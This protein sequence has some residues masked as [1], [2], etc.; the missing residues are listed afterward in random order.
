MF[1]KSTDILNNPFYTI[2]L[3]SILTYGF[4]RQITDYE[5]LIKNFRFFSVVVIVFSSISFF[6]SILNEYQFEYMTFSYNL[7]PFVSF[8]FLTKH[9]SRI[10]TIIAIIGSFLIFFSG[11]RGPFIFLLISI[12]VFSK[13][14]FIRMKSKWLILSVLFSFLIIFYS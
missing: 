4:A 2:L 13:D 12:L 1:T 6:V 10:Y 7:L 5:I 14:K 9:N 3:F 8:M 11:A